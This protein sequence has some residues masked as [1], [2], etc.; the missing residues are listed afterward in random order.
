[1]NVMAE[2]DQLIHNIATTINQ[3]LADAAEKAV[4]EGDT[5]YLRDANGNP[6]QI[7]QKIASDGYY[8][9]GTYMEENV[10]GVDFRINVNI[11]ESDGGGSFETFLRID[12]FIF[13][14]V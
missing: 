11:P 14:N 8:A 13:R 12:D 5:T 2:F 4:I 9:D 3:V 10:A 7:F 1:M 6:I